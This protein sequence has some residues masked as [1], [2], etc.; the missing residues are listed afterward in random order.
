MATKNRFPPVIAALAVLGVAGCGWLFP[1]GPPEEAH[2]EITSDD[3]GQLTVF[4]SQNFVRYEEQ[5][6]AGEPDCPIVLVL[7]SADTLTVSSPYSNT[8]E[9][10]DRHQ[11]FVE[12]HPLDE[13]EARVAMSVDIDGKEW[14]D[15]IRF[16]SPVTD[17]GDRETMRFIYQFSE[18]QT[19]NPGV[20]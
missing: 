10:N 2:V 3:V 4:V 7:L 12:T 6:C 11:I 15:E 18:N 13:V 1:G 19:L 16:L 14:Y 17:G 8:F 20:R 5:D 9:F